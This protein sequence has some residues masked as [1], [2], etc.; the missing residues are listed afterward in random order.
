MGGQPV[1]CDLTENV[2][3]IT[4]ELYALGLNK[5]SMPLDYITQSNGPVIPRTS[6]VIPRHNNSKLHKQLVM[7]LDDRYTTP[8]SNTTLYFV[9][10]GL[11]SI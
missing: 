6:F 11:L 1:I 4:Q 9:F 2:G 10:I 5:N 3:Q 7:K 8:T